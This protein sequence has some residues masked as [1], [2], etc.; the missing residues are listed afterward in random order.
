MKL[1]AQIS[2]VDYVCKFMLLGQLVVLSGVA[3]GRYVSNMTPAWRE[4]M[5]IFV[6]VLSQLLSNRKLNPLCRRKQLC[7]YAPTI[8]WRNAVGR[9]EKADDSHQHRNPETEEVKEMN[10]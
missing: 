3:F 6:L 2:I 10:G 4:E 7:I 8:E 9:P 1:D 5:T